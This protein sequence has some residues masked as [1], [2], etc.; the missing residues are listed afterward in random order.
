MNNVYLY[1]LHMNDKFIEET[2][3]EEKKRKRLDFVFPINVQLTE[4]KKRKNGYDV[5]KLK[6]L[7]DRRTSSC[8][9]RKS[10][11]CYDVRLNIFGKSKH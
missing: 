7:H 2:E 4:I 3:K 5:D 6:T 10:S 9:T 8:I 11:K 1:E